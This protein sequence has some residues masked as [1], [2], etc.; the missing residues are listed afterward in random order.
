M[1]HHHTV[2]LPFELSARC[3]KNAYE[4]CIGIGGTGVVL[5]GAHGPAP[6][7]APS[8]TSTEQFS[9]YPPAPCLALAQLKPRHA[10]AGWIPELE[11]YCALKLAPAEAIAELLIEAVTLA[12]ADGKIDGVVRMRG[13]LD[14]SAALPLKEH[15]HIIT[16][17]KNLQGDLPMHLAR[18]AGCL[19]LDMHA[20]SLFD[21]L[22][23]HAPGL[24]LP[25]R[26]PCCAA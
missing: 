12:L 22:Y 16:S 26:L 7:P 2:H 11:D 1:K 23:G 13:L 20:G 15:R 25:G 3:V 9:Y 17:M 5:V 19:V 24:Y 8:S 4:N 10:V 18:G 21:A 14:C 6:S